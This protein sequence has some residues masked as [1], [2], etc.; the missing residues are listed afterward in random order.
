MRR[1]LRLARR[2][3][4]AV[5]PNPKVG[6]V[7]VAGGKIVGE[8]FHARYGGP[9]AEAEALKQAGK[10]A[11]GATVFVTLEPCRAHPGK[12][13]P[14]CADALIKAGVAQVVAATK[15]PSG[16]GLAALKKAGLKTT[17]G[18]L[19]G[20]AKQLNR[21][22]FARMEKTRPHVI[23]KTALSLDGRAHTASGRSKW[24]TGP[25]ARQEAHKL[26]AACDAVLVGSGTVL[27]DDPSLTSHGA[28]KNPLRVILDTHLRTP[29]RSRC[30]DAAAPTII[31]T[32]S[33]KRLSGA[34][35]VRVPASKDGVDLKSVLKTLARRGVATLLVEGGPCVHAAFLA[36]GVVDEAQVFLAPKLIL[37]ADD[38]NRAPALMNPRLRRVGRDYLVSGK[39]S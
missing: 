9:H 5:Y 24:I 7:I 1:A 19:G 37:G 12:K 18:L 13:T 10:K 38:P 20:E 26:R 34:E 29:P 21:D 35:T 2:G 22:F 8:G 30:L 3:G 15:D 6:C 32:A 27:A 23:L 17:V 25:R 4:K 31:F 28:G 39:V 11:R 33:S 14:P 16:G 36:A